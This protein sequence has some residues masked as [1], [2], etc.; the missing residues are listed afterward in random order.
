MQLSHERTH[1]MNRNPN[2]T[3][4][5]VQRLALLAIAALLIG[6]GLSVRPMLVARAATTVQAFNITG[7]T[8]SASDNDYTRIKNAIAGAMN[9]DTIILSG[10]F[11]WTEANAAAS[12]ALGNDGVVSTDDDYSILVPAGLNNV[13]LTASSLGAATIQGPGDLAAVN[14]EGV[15]VFDGGPNQ[16]WTISNIRFVEFDLSIAFF[17]GA[18]GVTA[19]NNTKITNNYIKIAQ[20]LNATVAP[21]DVNQNIGIHFSF[22]ANQMISGNTI[23]F[24]GDGVSDSAMGNFSTQV[25][26]QSNTSGGNVYDGLQITNNILRVLNA[27]SAN[28]EVIL[29]I[30]ENAHGHTSNI[31]VSGNQFI[32]LAMAN[33]PGTNLQRGFRV[34]SHSSATTMVTY[35]NNTVLGANIGFQW[36]AGS[37]F[38]G[39][40]P[41]K[42]ISNNIFNNG[43]GVLV[44]SQGLANLS[45]NRIVGNS[46]AGTNNVDGTLTAENNWWGCNF[47]PGVGGAG[48]AGTAN[49]VTGSTDSNPWLVLR[50]TAVP[51]TILV[52]GTSTLTADLTF[53]SD[54]VDTH[55]LGNVP[56]GIPVGFMGNAFG[57]VA[58]PS[59]STTSGKAN[60]TYT[61]TAPGTGNVSTLVDAQTVTTSIT[62]N[63]APCTIT[64]PPNKTQS[65]DPN[66][67]G[68]VVT[69][70]DPTTTGTCGTV[71]CNPASGL[72]FPVG[73]TTVTCTN[74]EIILSPKPNGPRGGSCLPNTITEST[75]Q[76]VTAQNSFSCNN[77]SGHSDNSY[78]RA[79]TLTAFSIT[80]NFDVQSVDI[81]IESATS[82]GVVGKAAS[83]GSAF[84]RNNQKGNAPKGGQGQP[85]TLRLYTNTGGAF[86]GGTRNLIATANYT[87][88]DQAL[89]IVNLPIS[90]FVPAGSEL[91]VEAF[92]PNGQNSGNL[93]F[94]GSNAEV[95]TG[96]SYVSAPDCKISNPTPTA[97]IK[98]PDMHIVMNV[99]GCEEV[100]GCTFNVTV[101]D[102][103]PPSI[104]CPANITQTTDPN[105][106]SAVV[107]YPDPDVTDNC[108]TG[109]PVCAPPSGSAFPKGA[110][111]VTCS[112]SDSSGNS[113]SCSFAVTVND[114]QPPQ[115]TCPANVTAVTDQNTCPNPACQSVNYA[116]PVAT[117]NC[118]GVIVVC[119]PPSGSCFPTGVTTVTCTATDTSGNT[120]TCSFPVSI[121]DTALQDDSN[122]AIILLW[123]SIS[124]QYRFCCNGITFTGVGKATRQGCVYTLDQTNAIDRRVLG[125]VDKA[126]HAG[127]GSIQAPAGTIRCTI[128]DRNTLN[129]TNVTSCQ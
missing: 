81:G 32:N 29:G 19:F 111:T 33:N 65:N 59:T 129:D 11:N 82:G 23:E 112:V 52:G 39:N 121:F 68:A 64:C 100:T 38:A 126:V 78:W 75:S 57:A 18:G 72:F 8:P 89:T 119:N 90:A 20:D 54:N 102:T 71:I 97:D 3:P 2:R 24:D 26:M 45:F 69:F 40:Q 116:A 47:G 95:E 122:P 103:Q 21:A 10:N 30:W 105:Q 34:T 35:Q 123:N 92:T 87:I 120:A 127:S 43:T 125:R 110:T 124:G 16:G 77:M 107:V 58:P 28:P 115:I 27:Q 108:P 73:T 46:V 114:T 7:G 15:L 83:T 85:L 93:F 106:C 56:D 91:V 79:F 63:P 37:N 99:N 88:P 117:D 55:L 98:F 5:T 41:V 74:R 84:S 17:N 12:W 86:P 96:P 25:G 49:G 60:S 13:T 53:N 66:Q 109:A 50:L 70:N 1:I 9:G 22:G 128:G 62:V 42:L 4:L 61:G 80:N 113:A 51:G 44:Q 67:C 36:I 48:C 14:L 104:T 101:Q 76:K 94:I 6:L 118:P 31:T